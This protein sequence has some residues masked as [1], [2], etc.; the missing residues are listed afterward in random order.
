MMSISTSVSPEAGGV[1]SK[2]PLARLVS[3]LSVGGL[4][5]GL[6]A[7]I[8]RAILPRLAMGERVVSDPL[9]GGRHAL[10]EAP[11]TRAGWNESWCPCAM[12]TLRGRAVGGDRRRP[13]VGPAA[14]RAHEP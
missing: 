14:G 10:I 1:S 11:G 12:N 8:A 7:V 6:S 4:A 13:V 3:V 5:D 2:A 9:S